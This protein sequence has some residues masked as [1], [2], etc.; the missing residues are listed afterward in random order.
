MHTPSLQTHCSILNATYTY[1]S[2][3][4]TF[5][6]SLQYTNVPG[7]AFPG[8]T[9]GAS[10]YGGAFLANYSFSDN[11]NLSGRWEYIAST[12]SLA[13]GNANL[14]YGPGSDA[15]SFTL[16]PTWQLGVGFVRGEASIVKAFSSPLGFAFGRLGNT[17]TQARFLVEAGVVF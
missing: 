11:W 1:N 17:S 10:T 15:F 4:W 9:K 2:A 8:P 7:N 5:T 16:T 6:P 12:G 3:P 14:L 13:N